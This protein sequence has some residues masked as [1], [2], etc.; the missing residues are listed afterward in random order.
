MGTFKNLE[1][2]EGECLAFDVI[3]PDCKLK[4]K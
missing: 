2:W 1:C 4:I 3:L